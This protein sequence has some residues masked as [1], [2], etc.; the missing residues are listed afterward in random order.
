MRYL[1]LYE[2]YDSIPD[3][4]IRLDSIGHVLDPNEGLIYA[5]WKSHST[6]FERV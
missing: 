6:D 3:N 5:I 1:K 2:E 4:F